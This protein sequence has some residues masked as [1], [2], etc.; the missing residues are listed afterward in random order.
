[1]DENYIEKNSTSKIVN[2]SAYKYNAFR[3]LMQQIR[4][5]KQRVH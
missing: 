5:I 1:M 3:N 4:K 2:S